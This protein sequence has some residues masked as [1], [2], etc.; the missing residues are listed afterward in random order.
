MKKW[1]GILVLVTALLF[2]L[3]SINT[4]NNKEATFD[5]AE[6]IIEPSYEYGI[7]VDSFSGHSVGD[8]MNDDYNVSVEYAKKEMRPGFYYDNHRM[9]YSLGYSNNVTKTGDLITLPYTDTDFIM[10]P[11]SSTTQSL[12]P[13]NITN[14]IGGIKT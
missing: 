11:L 6:K 3:A 1:I 12:N 4:K 8:V 5:V 9:T 13:F 7:L 14:W 2:L 10:Q